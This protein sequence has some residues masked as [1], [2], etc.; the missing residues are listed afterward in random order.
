MKDVIDLLQSRAPKATVLPVELDL[1]DKLACGQLVDLHM[2][3]HKSL[4]TIVLNHG[5][6]EVQSDFEDITDDQW[7]NTFSVNIHGHYYITKAALKHLPKGGTITMNASVN[8]FIGH[9]KLIDYTATKGAMV[10]FARA[11]SNNIVGS[12]GVR[13]NG[14]CRRTLLTLESGYGL[15]T[16]S[17]R[18]PGT[19]LDTFDVSSVGPVNDAI[20]C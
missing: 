14:M 11:L 17:S 3:H 1:T 20:L 9:P 5:T 18:R 16:K 2:A 15:T 12:K 4:D 8:P 19:D 6:Q 13:V 10:A 7:L